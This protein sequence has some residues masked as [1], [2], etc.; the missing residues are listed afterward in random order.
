[1]TL[2]VPDSASRLDESL[3]TLA[4]RKH[5]WA[6]LPIGTKIQYL[7]AVKEGLGAVAH[8]WVRAASQAKGLAGNSPLQGE[9]WIS[10]P[11]ATAYALD[12]YAETLGEIRNAGSLRFPPARV[13][14]R[15][16]RT[17]VDAF[18]NSAADRLLFMGMRAETRMLAGVT[19]QQLDE[20]IAPFYREGA[21]EGRVALVLGAGNIASIPP[22]DVLYK[23]VAEGAVCILKINPVNEYLGPFFEQ[24]FSAFVDAGFLRF[25]YGGAD[26]GRYLCAHELVEEIHITGSDKTYDAIVFG[27]GEEGRARKRRNEPRLEKPVTSELGNVS[28]TIVVPGPWSKA[29]IAFQAEHIATQKLH[30][31]G[32]NCIASQVLVLPDDWPGTPKLLKKLAA[33]FADAEK[34]P[35]YYPGA[36]QRRQRMQSFGES[37]EAANILRVDPSLSAAFREEAFCD[38]LTYTQLNGGLD[39]YLE[40]AVSLANQTLW[41]TLGA[42]IIVHPK[43]MKRHK[44]EI[45]RAIDTLRY[46]TIGVN[47]WTGV[48]YCL[49]DIPW[50]AYPGHAR[51]DIQS[52]SGVVHNAFLFS[53]TEKSVVYAP[54]RPFPPKPVWFITH[55]R[56]AAVGERLFRYQMHHSPMNVA[57]VVTAALRG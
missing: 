20:T 25:A 22:L 6:R 33:T 14:V 32:F 55:R 36:M 23:F 13:H 56:A 44:R 48:G 46:G 26:V 24:M 11:W 15:N 37:G 53:Q 52:G 38:V 31:G 49:A 17:V 50:G 34:R 39:D 27:E 8:D 21:P 16:G 42:N 29:D 19:P 9:E 1:M 2:V 57:A 40:R 54:F 41:G 12:R 35:P 28:P 3:R 43:T 47:V 51:A 10:G 30:N 45:E 7:R 18:P 4:S 5:A